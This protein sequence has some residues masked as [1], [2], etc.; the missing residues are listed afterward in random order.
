MWVSHLEVL[1][2]GARICLLVKAR[3]KAIVDRQNK[4]VDLRKKAK[5][6]V[7]LG[8]DQRGGTRSCEDCE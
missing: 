1:Q 2:I 4:K 8:R 3:G 7:V 5:V 6:K